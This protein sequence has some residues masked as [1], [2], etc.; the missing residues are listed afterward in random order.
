[1]CLIAGGK[2]IAES[3]AIPFPQVTPEW[4][5]SE[6]PQVIVKAAAHIDGY[7]LKN[8]EPFDRKRDDIMARPAWSH[9]EAVASGRVH[10][11]DSAIWTGPRAIIGVAYLAGWFHPG[12]I[13][14]LNPESMHREY[15]KVF[16]GVEYQ[17]V[18][19]STN[20]PVGGR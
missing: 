9:I 4:V 10:I 19:V 6:N 2:N 17:G 12:I 13:K 15:L 7:A 11:I 8:G 1:M 20:L 3:L 16:Q 14:A 18:Y 5:V